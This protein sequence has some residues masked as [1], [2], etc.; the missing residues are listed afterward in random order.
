[1]KNNLRFQKSLNPHP[2]SCNVPLNEIINCR[3][4]K[5]WILLARPTMRDYWQ[6][7]AVGGQIVVIFVS[8]KSE[9]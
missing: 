7:F 3:N 1:M 8:V 2:K 5:L 4:T 6:R 9:D